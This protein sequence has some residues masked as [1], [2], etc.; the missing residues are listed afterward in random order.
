MKRKVCII[1]AV[2]MA[3]S[4]AGCGDK[5][6]MEASS[7]KIVK[8]QPVDIKSVDD[9]LEYIGFVKAKETKNYSFLMAG[10]I[11]K[12]NVKKGDRFK[13]GDVLAS[14]DTT[15][16]EFSA[17]VGSNTTEQAQ[18]GLEKTIS[19]YN[20]NIKSA[21]NSIDT[22]DTSIDAAKTGIAAMENALVAAQQNIDAGQN[23]LDTLYSKLEGTRKLHEAG[24]V[25][26]KDM[27]ALEA[28]YVSQQANLEQARAT[29]RGTEAE[30][31][32]KRAELQGLNDKRKTAVETLENLK[33]SK[34]EDI[35]SIK[36]QISS[37][38]IGESVTQ[39]NINDAVITAENDG[40]VMEL[41]FKEGEVTSA[42]YP[43]VVAKSMSSV[44]S[45]GVPSDEY[46][47]IKVGQKAVIND[48]IEGVI[49]T[50]AQYPDENT[51]T[52]QVEIDVDSENV[53]MGETVGVKIPTGSKE[54]CFVPIRAVFDLGGVDYVYVVN[55]DSRVVR[56]RVTLGEISGDE[57]C[58]EIDD[59]KA[60][61]V[62]EGIKSLR[63][64]DLVRTDGKGV[65]ADGQ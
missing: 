63:E 30:L 21:Q 6:D 42:G 31:K 64:N 61:I 59:P 65:V 53:T 3:L 54:G 27:E 11:A 26:D 55:A 7:A 14:L 47:K 10:K 49:S 13:K 18:A 4:C 40:Y 60:V 45:I 17:G 34:Q 39:K 9:G 33:R 57:V 41:P 62:T 36:S 5:G 8:I 50:I 43:V 44:V 28:Q 2:L 23:A 38:Q 15:A 51:R 22:L 24:L 48:D 20:T 37:A 52:Y 19:T 35:R 1:F 16:L 58:V 29:Y 25:T 46:R 32:G 56:K 12:I